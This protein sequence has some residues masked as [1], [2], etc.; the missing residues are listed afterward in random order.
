[1]IVLSKMD[2]T[3]VVGTTI[4]GGETQ[5]LVVVFFVLTLYTLRQRGHKN[6]ECQPSHWV[7]MLAPL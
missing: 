7:L 3:S 2:A 6:F 5:T 4:G 1:M